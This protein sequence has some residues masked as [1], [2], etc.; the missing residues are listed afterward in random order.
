MS[1]IARS[2]LGV[3]VCAAV[4]FAVWITKD[5]SCLWGLF[6]AAVVANGI[7]ENRAERGEAADEDD[8]EEE[9]EDE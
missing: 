5:A 8:D 7:G 2:M 4:A 1:N 3:A 6:F 9:E